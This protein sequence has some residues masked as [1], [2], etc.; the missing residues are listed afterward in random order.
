M[1]VIETIR[2]YVRFAGWVQFI[3]VYYRDLV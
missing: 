2:S 1:T 3:I